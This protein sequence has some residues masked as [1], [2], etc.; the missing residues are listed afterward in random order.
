MSGFGDECLHFVKRM[1]ERGVQIKQVVDESTAAT[2]RYHTLGRDDLPSIIN[3]V[4]NS[5]VGPGV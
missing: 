4:G 1:Q 5:T 2:C 3:P